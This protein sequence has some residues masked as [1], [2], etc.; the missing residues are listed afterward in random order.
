MLDSSERL[1]A[2]LI[3]TGARVEE[4]AWTS[5][6]VHQEALLQFQVLNGKYNELVDLYHSGGPAAAPA[7]APS[8]APTALAP[9]DR[10]LEEMRRGQPS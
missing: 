9:I 10:W 5:G 2:Q 8:T 7:P 1:Q 6:V 3:A 4:I